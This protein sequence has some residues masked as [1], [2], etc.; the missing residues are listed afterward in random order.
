MYE[1]GA[2]KTISIEDGYNIIPDVGDLIRVGVDE[3][4][5][6]GMVAINYDYDKRTDGPVDP[7]IKGEHTLDWWKTYNYIHHE[8]RL[9]V[10]HAVSVDGDILEIGNDKIGS[11]NVAEV[12]RVPSSVP[13]IIYDEAEDEFITGSLGDIMPSEIYGI[14]CSEVIIY[15]RYAK[16]LAVYVMNNRD[17]TGLQ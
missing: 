15:T 8:N 13:L 3:K 16:P 6:C 12:F 1:R 4:G 11:E 7:L 9:V 10:G 14:D 17:K 2:E 5:M